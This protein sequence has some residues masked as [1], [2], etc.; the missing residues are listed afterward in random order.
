MPV[1]ARPSAAFVAGRVLF[2]FACGYFLSYLFRSV[3]AVIAP[4]LQADLGIGA[5]DLGMLTAAYFVTFAAAQLPVGILLDRFG[6]PRVQA[7]L[8]LIAAIGAAAFASADSLPLLTL[9]RALIGFGV[10]GGLMSAMKAIAIW[11][12][13][14]RWAFAN[15]AF[16]AA[17]GLG[18]LAA[19]VPVEW[20]LQ[21]VRWPV[22]F[23]VL[24]GLSVLAALQ[25]WLA[26]P[27]K[28][29][30]GTGDDVSLAAQLRDYWAFLLDARF[31][32]IAP[33][34]VIGMGSGMSIQTLW[35]GP[36]LR[37]VGG[38]DQ[39]HAAQIQFLLAVALTAG[40]MVT[41]VIADRLQ[42]F[43]VSL[44]QTMIWSTALYAVCLCCLAAGLVPAS[45]L[46]W[47]AFGLICLTTV[48]AYPII[49]ADFP[50]EKSG[51]VN[52]LLNAVVFG[53]AFVIQ[54]GMGWIIDL[55]PQ[56]ADGRYPAAAYQWS[57]GILAVL[58]VVTL[59]WYALPLRD[60][61]D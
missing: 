58:L 4:N 45:P 36:F 29:D 14:D 56:A 42:R 44:A 10:A 24:G 40:F 2:P 15:G 9:A 59:V 23:W 37:D 33:V 19:T 34:S 1:P 3:N 25:I 41:G 43:G 13:R 52:A 21:F 39:S 30:A 49:S 50:V 7:G 48:L 28:M 12:P 57:F 47:I 17:G 31:L 54:A 35:T 60:R 22:L 53:L 6:P 5:G 46:L 27:E 61:Q 32:K 8:L 20:G 38:L 11:L 51:R 26:V 18:A 55:W 16:M